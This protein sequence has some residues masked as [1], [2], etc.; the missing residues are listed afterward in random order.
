MQLRMLSIIIIN[1]RTPQLLSDC[2]KT[3]YG[4]TT[5]IAFE[6]IVVDNAS[7]DNSKE[8]ILARYASVKWIS[9]SYNSGFARANNEG[10]RQSVGDTVLL[11]NSDTLVIENAIGDCY[12]SFMKDEYAACG[13]QLL[14]VD[15]SPQISGNYFVPGGL[16]NLLSLPYLGAFIKWVGNL[17]KVKKPHVPDSDK[18]IEVDWINGAYL[19]VKKSCINKAGLLDE[20]FFL[21]AEEAEWCYRLKKQGR[22]VIYGQFK[23]THLQ[24]ET[25]NAA[26]TSSGRGYSNLYDRKGLQIMVSN[27]VRIRKQNGLLWFLFQL[28]MFTGNILIFFVAIVIKTILLMIKKEEMERFGKY[29]ANILRVWTYLIRI[30]SGRPYFYKIL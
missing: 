17:F 3:V 6:V 23:V 12:N 14:N 9:M 4:Q 28:L 26:F 13:V 30:S 5:G 1:F 22:L 21:Y 16:N 20:D 10:I 24:G 15:G 18:A 19:M 7:G 8:F 27:F 11:L 29:T 25:S 2:L